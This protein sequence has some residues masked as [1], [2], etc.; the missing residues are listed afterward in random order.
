LE[1]IVLANA[2][3][4]VDVLPELGGKLSSL[5]FVPSNTELLQQPLAPYAPRTMNMG[6]EESDAS[7]FDECFPSVAACNVNIEGATVV[8]PDHGDFWRL[9]WRCEKRNDEIHLS[10]TGISLPFQ[11]DKVLRLRGPNLEITYTVTNIGKEHRPYIWSAHPLFAVD[12]GDRIV[13][14]ESVTTV[15][16]ESSVGERLG[17]AGSIHTWPRTRMWDRMETDLSIAGSIHAC[18]G[19]M[20]FTNAPAEGWAALERMREGICIEVRFN[21]REVPYLGLW[22]CYG[23][24][25]ES[26]TARQ[27]CVAIEPCTASRGSLTE[28]IDCNEACSLAPGAATAWK[29]QIGVCQREQ[30]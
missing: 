7:G 6:F 5:R 23:G 22:L 4:E 13:L 10:A 17:T 12:A 21:P 26:K 30:S 11:F 16:V 25:P 1:T 19:D 14:P 3:L 20:L 8:I 15:K 9:S 2:S 24:W 29:M 28:A 27:Q 18:T